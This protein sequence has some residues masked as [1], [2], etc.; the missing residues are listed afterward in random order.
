[1]KTK[2]T[3]IKVTLLFLSFVLSSTIYSQDQ[4]ENVSFENWEDVGLDNEEPEQWS[5]VKTTDGGGF[6]NGLAPY[7]WEKSINAHTG[8]YSVRLYNG[9]AFGFDVAGVLTNGRLHATL[10]GEGWAFTDVNNSQWNTPCNSKPDSI[11]IWAKYFPAGGDIGQLKAVLHTGEAIIPDET[12]Q[13]Y[14]ATADIAIPNETASWTRFSAPFNYING[15]TPEYIL[16]VLSS[17]D[18]VANEGTEIF[19]DD[20]ELIY[21]DVELDLTAFLE[22]PYLTNGQMSNSLTPDHLPNAQPYSGAPW[23]YSGTES[24]LSLPNPDIVDWVLVEIRDAASASTATSFA[25]VGKQAGFLLKDG[26]IVGLDGVSNL[27][28]PVYINQD[29]FTIVWHRNH[30]PIMSN[31]PLERT[32]GV[33]QYDY[34]SSS[35]QIYGGTDGAVQLS[36][37]GPDVWGMIGGDGNGDKTINNDDKTNFWSILVGKSGYLS[38]DY[39]MD[40]QINNQD[41]NEVWLDNSGKSSQIP[42]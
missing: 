32:N 13:N 19:Y 10:A 33:Y 31:Y 29:L 15:D 8:N 24:F 36:T 2:N 34:S 23:N 25:T 14:V 30:L 35:D 16:F 6:V 40:G 9:E 11:V 28:F 27:T 26:S 39:N 41:K 18:V 4:P 21:N 1:M 20:L 7:V 3:I 5:S 37:F 17:A 22:G 38:S 42:N 12:E